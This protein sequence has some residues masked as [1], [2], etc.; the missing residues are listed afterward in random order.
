MGRHLSWARL[1]D[2]A[3]GGVRH[4]RRPTHGPP[5]LTGSTSIEK[6]PLRMATSPTPLTATSTIG[7]WLDSPVGR[8]LVRGLLA[9]SGASEDM[10]APVKGLPLQQLVA[11][12]Q[13]QM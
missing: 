2:R 10:L 13:G 4:P 7:Q 9:Q 8:P 6:G 3:G 5:G 11:M 1:E 12:S